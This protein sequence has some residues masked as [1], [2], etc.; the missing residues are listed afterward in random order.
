MVKNGYVGISLPEEFMQPVD[1]IIENKRHGFKSRAD[2]IKVAIRQYIKEFHD[3]GNNG[4][5]TE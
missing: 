2:F 5:D 1:E 3:N 4:S